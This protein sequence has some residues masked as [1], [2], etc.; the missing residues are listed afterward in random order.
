MHGLQ[1]GRLLSYFARFVRIE[2]CT[3]IPFFGRFHSDKNW[4]KVFD[5][6]VHGK[7]TK[8]VRISRQNRYDLYI[9]ETYTKPVLLVDD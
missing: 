7:G 5:R 1:Q 4:A 3:M 2:C 8:H 6:S 9:D